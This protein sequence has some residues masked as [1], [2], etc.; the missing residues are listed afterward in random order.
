MI[1]KLTLIVTAVVAIGGCART[2]V[3]S[4]AGELATSVPPNAHRLTVGTMIEVKTTS[5][6]SSEHDKVG[7]K[8]SARV[9]DRVMAQN[10]QTA[11]PEGAM[12]YGH[13]TGL[14]NA[15]KAGEPSVIRLDFDRIEINGHSYPYNAMVTEVKVPTTSSDLLKKAGIGA[16]AGGA[17]GAIISGGDLSKMFVGAAIGA[18]AGTAISLGTDREAELPAGTKLHLRTSQNVA[19]R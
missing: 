10:G 17:L 12:V 19:L 15:R 16:A 5:K 14:E 9:D 13:I 4:A 18:A 11:V 7:D 3:Q 8:F 2:H 1:R 6:L